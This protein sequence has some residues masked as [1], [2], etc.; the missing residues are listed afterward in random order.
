MLF[1]FN[2][3]LSHLVKYLWWEMGVIHLHKM[4]INGIKLPTADYTDVYRQL[5]K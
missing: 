3:H 4:A 5:E 1:V 2:R